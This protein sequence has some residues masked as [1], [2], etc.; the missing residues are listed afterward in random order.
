MCNL[1]LKILIKPGANRVKNYFFVVIFGHRQSSQCRIK[2]TH[3]L[4]RCI[5]ET[6]N[7]I[8]F[9]ENGSTFDDVIKSTVMLANIKDYKKMNKIYNVKNSNT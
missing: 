9:K 2:N 7:N 1:N 8:L 3:E 4:Q 6:S 5:P